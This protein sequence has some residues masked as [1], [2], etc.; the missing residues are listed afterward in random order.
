MPQGR[1]HELTWRSQTMVRR[2]TFTLALLFIVMSLISCGKQD[3]STV[4]LTDADSGS[5]V[6]LHQGD[7]L[8]IV[9]PS[10]PTTGYTWEVKPGSEAVLKQKGEPE[11]R[12]DSN[13][14]GS[15]G[16]MTFRFDAIAVGEV[17]LV[18][19]YG[20]TFEPGVAPVQT[21]DITARVVKN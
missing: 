10:N 1:F 13:V 18:L 7:I 2:I 6:K 8:E 21:F 3:G 15:G 16:R 19:I 20:R 12:P 17:P 11:F 9:L 5:T 4:Q 14:L